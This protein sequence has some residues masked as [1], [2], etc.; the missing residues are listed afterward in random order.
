[1]SLR[2]YFQNRI[3]RLLPT[4]YSVFA[5]VSAYRALTMRSNLQFL[6]DEFPQHR[7]NWV[8]PPDTTDG[9]TSAADTYLVNRIGT[10]AATGKWAQEFELTW[11]RPDYPCGLDLVVAAKVGATGGDDLN[12][13]VRVVP[14]FAPYY[15]DAS[16][17]LFREEAQTSGA[18]TTCVIDSQ[19]MFS[20]PV[21]Q[22]SQLLVHSV[23]EDSFIVAPR[24]MMARIEIEMTVPAD[25]TGRILEVYVR[26]FVCQ[27]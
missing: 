10:T 9:E 25:D 27:S 6:I 22:G 3:M 24:A 14:Y 17:F 20:E 18:D 12:L 4:S 2:P 1:M 19:V 8:S 21:D 13:L 26:E 7:V 11:I 23:E 16:P 15:D 5:P